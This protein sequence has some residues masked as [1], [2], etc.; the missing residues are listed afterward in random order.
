M[1]IRAPANCGSEYFNYKKTNSVVLMALADAKY[2][3]TYV[4]VGA[5]GRE[6]DGGVFGKCSLAKVRAENSIGVPPPKSLPTT[7]TP[8]PYVIVADDAFPLK[9]YI[10]KPFSFRNQ[11]MTQR[12]FNYRLS[13]AR[14]IIENVFG[15]CAARFRL[16]LKPIDMKPEKVTKAVLA[17]CA[18]HNFLM[19]RTASRYIT[20]SDFD[21]DTDGVVTPGNWR[22]EL[23]IQHM[24]PIQSINGRTS[25]NAQ[26]IRE[27]F[28]NH[29]TSAGEVEWQ[30]RTILGTN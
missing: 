11:D 23:G 21:R 10:M 28:K 3:F 5:Y 12:V 6:S 1:N 14:R 15:I 2:R 25:H 18:L 22:A 9:N 17:I 4:D 7:N 27:E 20:D 16:L 24:Q 13:R 8:V 29:F 30:Y 26:A 19:T